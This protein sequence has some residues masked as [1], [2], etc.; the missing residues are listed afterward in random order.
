MR[1]YKVPLL[2]NTKIRVDFPKIFR[3]ILLVVMVNIIV[4]ANEVNKA[5][6]STRKILESHA[7]TIQNEL[8][9]DYAYEEYIA[10]MDQL[11]VIDTEYFEEV[12]VDTKFD[13]YLKAK[14]PSSPLIGRSKVFYDVTENEQQAKLL[15]AISGTE[16]GFG[17]NAWY[18]NAFGVMCTRD[19]KRSTNCGWTNWDYGI[20]R[21]YEV[22]KS[23]YQNWDGTKQGLQDTFIGSYCASECTYWV[24]STWE[25]YN[26]F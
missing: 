4:I 12:Y 17:T 2:K 16:S 24:S 18:F 9:L 22:T 3:A 19:G 8:R 15:M 23:F 6:L 5:D 14:F 10:R 21:A 20:K 11:P 25:F 13:L 7:Q 26:Q 1:K